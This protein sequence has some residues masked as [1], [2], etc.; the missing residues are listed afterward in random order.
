MTYKEWLSLRKIFMEE[1]KG[2][3]PVCQFCE[4]SLTPTFTTIDLS[5]TLEER[6]NFYSKKEPNTRDTEFF[7]DQD[8]VTLTDEEYM[9]YIM[10]KV[11]RP[12][13]Q[14]HYFN[15]KP[16]YTTEPRHWGVDWENNFCSKQCG[17][18]FGNVI[19]NQINK[20][21]KVSKGEN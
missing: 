11:N 8:W 13:G 17:F 21:Y 14:Q 16:D 3:K 18:D 1:W 15:N 20:G 7:K 2:K 9:D 6:F 4:K 5:P 12:P 10:K 19:C